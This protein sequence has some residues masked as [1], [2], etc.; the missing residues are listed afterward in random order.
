ME[1]VVYDVKIHELL[2]EPSPHATII[3]HESNVATGHQ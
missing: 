2:N 3:G 1:E